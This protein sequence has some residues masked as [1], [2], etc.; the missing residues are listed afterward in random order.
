[1]SCVS[2]CLLHNCPGDPRSSL[3]TRALP[4]H[5]P[6]CAGSPPVLSSTNTDCLKVPVGADCP[7]DLP[8]D[9]CEQGSW[10]QARCC[11]FLLVTPKFP[12][13]PVL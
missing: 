6:P 7:R 9:L 10:M 12:V 2:A 1:M 8:S 5:H 4:Q 11:T 13:L 3:Q